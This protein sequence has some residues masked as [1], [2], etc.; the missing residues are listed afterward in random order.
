MRRGIRDRIGHTNM[1]SADF[2]NHNEGMGDFW[3][4][5]RDGL[6]QTAGQTT[7][8]LTTAGK[9]QI[10]TM[11]QDPMVRQATS[12]FVGFQL[13]QHKGKLIFASS[14]LGGYILFSFINL[15]MA[16]R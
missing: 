13:S 9:Q 6:L 8:Q 2:V 4:D 15:A 16:R 12:E 5:L 10:V 3:S 14:L 7:T 1:G 11:L